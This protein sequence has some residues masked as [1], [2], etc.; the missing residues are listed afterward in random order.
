MMKPT[1][2]NPELVDRLE[3]SI[4]RWAGTPFIQGAAVPEVGVDCVHFVREV[5]RDCGIDVA[6]AGDIPRYKLAT[7][8][9]S[10]RSAVLAWLLDNPVARIHLKM[11]PPD[12]EVMPGD[13]AVLRQ[14][15]SAHHVG[16]VSPCGERV[17]HAAPGAGVISIPL[18]MAR[19]YSKHVTIFRHHHHA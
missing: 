5:Y 3:L 14:Y 7:G 8:I 18:D 16:I 13:I 10:D 2:T 17:W 9:F 11:M 4:G 19:R 15:R 1:F 12:A 6:P